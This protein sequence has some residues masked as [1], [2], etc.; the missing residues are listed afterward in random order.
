MPKNP[1]PWIKNHYVKKTR[2]K[3]MHKTIGGSSQPN[4]CSKTKIFR[5]VATD[6]IEWGYLHPS[7]PLWPPRYTILSI[8]SIDQAPIT[9]LRPT[10]GPAAVL[11]AE[12]RLERGNFSIKV[13]QLKEKGVIWQF[14]MFWQWRKQPTFSERA[15]V[16]WQSVSN[17]KY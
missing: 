5:G 11:L 9:L 12:H 4:I 13:Y 1:I 14:K 7:N 10:E 17:E 16:M 15:S 3:I 2:A 8:I 6:P